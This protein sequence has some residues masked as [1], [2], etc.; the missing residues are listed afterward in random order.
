MGHDHW[1]VRGH[2]NYVDRTRVRDLA[3]AELEGRRQVQPIL[4]FLRKHAS[5]FEKACVPD[6]PAVIGVWETRRILGD[7]SLTVREI[8][9]WATSERAVVRKAAFGI[10]IHN[11]DGIGHLCGRHLVGPS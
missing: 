4:E 10:D 8:V 5:G 1:D 6:M 2:V 11:P 3:Q 9:T 7:D